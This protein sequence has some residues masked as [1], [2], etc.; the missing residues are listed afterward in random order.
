VDEKENYSRP[1]I[2]VLFESAA[3]AYGPSLVGVILTGANSDG[4]LGLKKIKHR[5]GFTLVQEPSTAEVKTM[6][7]AAIKAQTPDRLLPLEEIGPFLGALAQG[8]TRNPLSE[9]IGE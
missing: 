6:P 1:S 9:K 8:I 7:E 4:A 3:D 5:G 2:D